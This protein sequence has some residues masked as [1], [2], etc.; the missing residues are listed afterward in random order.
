M[1]N[2]VLDVADLD[3]GVFCCGSVLEQRLEPGRDSRGQ[4]EPK[5]RVRILIIKSLPGRS[6][7]QQHLMCIKWFPLHQES[8]VRHLLVV[9]EVRV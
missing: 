3:A 4:S 8:D 9:Q 1:E 6:C 2:V 5:E 7:K